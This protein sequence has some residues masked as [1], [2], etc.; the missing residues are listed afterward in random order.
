MFQKIMEQFFEHPHRPAIGVANLGVVVKILVEII[1]QFQ[2]ELAPPG[3]VLDQSLGLQPHF[4][5][6]ANARARNPLLRRPDHVLHLRV[7]D[8]A[9]DKIATGF[10]RQISVTFLHRPGGVAPDAD[11]AAQL[12]LENESRC[13]PVVNIVA[14]VSDFISQVGYLRFQ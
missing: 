14:I 7:N 8:A 5:S 11:V 1:A 10:V 12:L 2:V 13:Q 6:R 4:I 9:D 3:T